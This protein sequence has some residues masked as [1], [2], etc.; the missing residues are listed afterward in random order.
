MA[1]AANEEQLAP[2]YGA[3]MIDSTLLQVRLTP[4]AQRDEIVGWEAVEET[5]SEQPCERLRVRVSAEPVDGKA[6]RALIKL[7]SPAL[8]IPSRDITIERG[9]SHRDKT[10]RVAGLSQ[11]ELRRRLSEG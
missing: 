7:L 1:Q 2:S 10:L 3:A 8:N 6:N 11:T 9:A 4:R 5:R